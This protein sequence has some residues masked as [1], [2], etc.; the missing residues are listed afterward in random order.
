[1]EGSARDLKASNSRIY[2]LGGNEQNDCTRGHDRKQISKI[3]REPHHM[4]YLTGPYQQAL[5]CFL[6]AAHSL[7]FSLDIFL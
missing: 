7:F 1:M 2:T 5:L 4:N 6:L 3:R